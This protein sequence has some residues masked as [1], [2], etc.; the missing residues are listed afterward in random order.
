MRREVVVGT[1]GV[2]HGFADEL[3]SGSGVVL[4]VPVGFVCVAHGGG[5]SLVIVAG[6]DVDSTLW[7]I[8]KIALAD[9]EQT[10]W[11]HEARH[12]GGFGAEGE[13]HVYRHLSVLEDGVVQVGHVAA[14]LP[15]DDASGGEGAR[16]R[17]V[18]AGDE[19]HAADQMHHEVAGDAG[20]VFLPAAPARIGDGVEGLFGR[21][22][23][24]GVP[25]EVF[26]REAGRRRILPRAGGIVATEG[27]LDGE[28]LAYGSGVID[29]LGLGEQGGAGALRADLDDASG[30]FSGGYDDGLD[31]GVGEE[32]LIFAR[33]G[34]VGAGNFFGEGLAAVPEIAGNQT[35]G[36]G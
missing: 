33:D 5:E 19:H 23:E 24:P 10:F 8:G 28:Q 22:A 36:A 31:V 12:L 6:G 4:L 11:S 30:L 18:D 1:S 3:L 34:D 32:L 25:V 13:A 26:G 21:G 27:E 14:V 15:A 17:L 20:A 7:D 9:F 2:N 16:G 35:F 29:L